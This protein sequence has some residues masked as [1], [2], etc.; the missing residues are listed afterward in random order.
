MGNIN[1]ERLVGAGLEEVFK[2]YEAVNER[3][4]KSSCLGISARVL[5]YYKTHNLLFPD[6]K[7]TKHEHLLFSF[8]EY[9]WFQIIV[10]L[11][12]YD[13]GLKVIKNIKE[14]LQSSLPMA[15]IM[16]DIKDSEN[17]INKFPE[18]LRNEF[19]EVL[20][21][22]IDWAEVD[23][24]YPVNLLSMALA[25]AIVK[26][27]LMTLMINSDDDILGFAFEDIEELNKDGAVQQ[28]FQ[29][30]F[31]SISLSEIIKKFIMTFDIK[32]ST[33]RLSLL[34]S[35]EAELI[36][37]LHEQK[38]E[39]L[40]VHLDHNN[41]IELIELK[42]SYNKLDKQARLLDIILQN[43]YQTI[44]LKTQDG[45]IVHCKNIRKIKPL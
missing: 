11:R 20:H 1:L 31:I 15:E 28:F 3:F 35:R 29:K 39:S 9:V 36:R 18:H 43:G 32:L 4:I 33:N 27:K 25:E 2:T 7:F 26:R 40:T 21:S 30:T 44:E 38:I 13:M 17:F 22:D 23:Q 10:E 45:K 5:S 14:V 19:L 41:T 16:P 42:E 24:Q 12:R 34:S 8:T 37:L 6:T